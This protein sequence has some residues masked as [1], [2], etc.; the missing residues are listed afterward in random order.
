MKKIWIIL[1][2]LLFALLACKQQTEKSLITKKIQYDVSIKSPN[3]AYDHWIQNIGQTDREIFVSNL[4][5]AVYNGQISAYD[6]F[7]KRL[8][9]EEIRQIGTDT[10]YRTLTRNYPP[11]AEYD[12]IIISKIEISDINKIRFLEAWYMDE[13]S[14]V[15]EKE[16]IGIAPVADK[17]DDEGNFMGLQPLF[18]I[19]P[20]GFDALKN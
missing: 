9:L 7:S 4:L 5:D 13:N 1:T 8:S 2:I 11:Y 15:F 3:P 6:Y 18:W 17:F 16:I 19:Y 14:L 12:T 20:K 10:A